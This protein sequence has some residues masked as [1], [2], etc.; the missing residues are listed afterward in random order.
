MI[1]IDHRRAF[2]ESPHAKTWENVSASEV[3]IAAVNAAMLQMQ[4][5]QGYA[6]DGFQV[7]QN[8]FRMEGARLFAEELMNLTTPKPLSVE[9][10]DIGNLDHTV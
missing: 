10:A 8:T 9:R 1:T 3:F 4:S 5:N 7:Q 2:S 6:K